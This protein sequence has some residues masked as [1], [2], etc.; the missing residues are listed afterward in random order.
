MGAYEYTTPPYRLSLSQ[1]VVSEEIP[2]SVF[3]LMSSKDPVQSF[4]FGISYDPDIVTVT[5][6]DYEGCPVINALNG[7]QGPFF[8]AG[9]IDPGRDFC[10]GSVEAGAAVS[11]IAAA[12]PS[13]PNVIPAGSDQA[14]ARFLFHA[15]PGALPGAESA[16]EFVDCL[17]D[18]VPWEIQ[19]VINFTGRTVA[20]ADGAITVDPERKYFLRGDVN[21]DRKRDISD[22]VFILLYL[23]D[24]DVQ[25]LGCKDAADVNDDGR[26]DIADA[27]FE[28][29]FLF[30]GGRKPPPPFSEPGPDPVPDA[31]NCISPFE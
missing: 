27:L 13:P 9:L 21:G 31:L 16:L 7:G 20:V 28:L 22:A 14:A 29:G 18:N 17:G 26:I 24:P 11:C 5:E 19:F 30:A 25:E 1:Y 3:P 10:E 8:F 6:I 4:V 12:D 15:V 2:V 23:F